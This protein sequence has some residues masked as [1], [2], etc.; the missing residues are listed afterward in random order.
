MNEDLSVSL[1]TR[2]SRRAFGR[3]ALAA[4][5]AAVGGAVF[6]SALS[7]RP[8][9]AAVAAVSPWTVAG[10]T[11]NP[12]NAVLG[13]KD[14][15]PVRIITSNIERARVSPDGNVGIGTQSPTARL[16]AVATG[17]LAALFQQRATAGTTPALTAT[18]A[19]TEG[20]A[21]LV[22]SPGGSLRGPALRALSAS[23]SASQVHPNGSLYDGAGEFAG[24]NGVIGAAAVGGGF[25]VV[26]VAMT[27]SS[28]GLYGYA[29]N[30][31]KALVA[32]GDADVYGTLTKS[33]GSFRIDHPLD[34]AR[35]Y[36]SH[37]FVESPDMKNVYDGV[38]SA[39]S[40][41]TAAVQM[42]AWFD[43]LNRDLRYQ[44]TPIGTAA[45]DLHVADEARDGRF[46]IAGARPGQ[47]ISWQVTGIRR[48]AWA[49]A[50][51]IPVEQDK[52]AHETGRFLHPQLH[53]AP[54]E[55]AIG[56][57]VVR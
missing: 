23:G 41:G 26:G 50:H 52:P 6:G 44:L 56:R 29:G 31:A 11:G 42:P 1:R 40:D 10:N 5:P 33:G 9:E 22:T 55:A 18:T 28:V 37:S 47:K 17:A 45:P 19:S 32:E 2:L 8:A 57:Q 25:G 39:D 13:T 4:V 7:P 36:L 38:V 15:K 27:A 43:A 53:G 35:R 49:D 34:P 21:L 3:G 30:G 54:A 24:P 12:S 20:P 46:T 16:H 51:R 48:D 14:T